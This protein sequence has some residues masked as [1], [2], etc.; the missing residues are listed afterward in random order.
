MSVTSAEPPF[1]AFARGY[2]KSYIAVG[3][4][5][6]LTAILLA[7]LFAPWISPQNPYDLAQLDI[8]DSKLEPGAKGGTGMTFWLGTSQNRGPPRTLCSSKM[9]G[10]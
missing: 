10:V 5:V 4:L 1:K 7:A 9:S 3:A 6:V 2:A 8:M